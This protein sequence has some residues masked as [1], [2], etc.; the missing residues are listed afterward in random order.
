VMT[1]NGADTINGM[2]ATPM[3]T[4]YSRTKWISDGV[5]KW[6]STF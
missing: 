4:A 6:T 1:A 5:S 3:T 2:A